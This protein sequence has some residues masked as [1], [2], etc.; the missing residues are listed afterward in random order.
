MASS[1]IATLL[2]DGGRTSHSAFRIP[3]DT[4][5]DLI[6]SITVNSNTTK[7][8]RIA[9]LIVWDEAPAQ[10]RHSAEAVDRTFRDILQRPDIPFGEKVV[11]FGGDFRQCPPW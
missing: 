7:V 2:L 3:I 5:R 11:V 6:C 9:R 1:G 10:H 4:D 8:I